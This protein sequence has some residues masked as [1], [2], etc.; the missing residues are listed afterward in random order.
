MTTR[1]S[2]ATKKRPGRPLKDTE[3]ERSM[4]ETVALL[5]ELENKFA[6][7]PE[8]HVLYEAYVAD[9]EARS[10]AGLEA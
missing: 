7:A 2:S 3:P 1:E 6:K 9:F 4:E 5:R 10:V 8:Q